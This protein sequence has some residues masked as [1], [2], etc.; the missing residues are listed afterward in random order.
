MPFPRF[1]RRTQVVPVSLGPARANQAYED[2]L[3]EEA[4]ARREAARQQNELE[5]QRLAIIQSRASQYAQTRAQAQAQAAATQAAA[6]QEAATQA[7]TAQAQA[8]TAQAATAQASETDALSFRPG[9]LIGPERNRLRREVQAQLPNTD[10]GAA[11]TAPRRIGVRN[12]VVLEHDEFGPILPTS[13]LEGQ[14]IHPGHTGNYAADYAFWDNQVDV[15]ERRI[16]ALHTTY[17]I[18]EN[19]ANVRVNNLRTRL[20]AANPPIPEEV[21]SAEVEARYN[22]IEARDELRTYRTVLARNSSSS[23]SNATQQPA[24]ARAHGQ[25]PAE[26]NRAQI[27]TAS[28][29]AVPEAGIRERRQTLYALHEKYNEV[30]RLQG[31]EEEEI[32]EELLCPLTSEF[33]V[34]PVSEAFAEHKN[35]YERSNILRAISMQ[36]QRTQPL[37]PFTRVPI[38]PCTLL[39]DKE[40]IAKM[41]KYEEKMYRYINNY[42][43]KLWV[44]GVQPQRFN[45]ASG[46]KFKKLRKLIQSVKNRKSKQRKQAKQAKQTTQANRRHAKLSKKYKKQYT[47]RYH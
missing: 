22:I 27:Q 24:P 9:A 23:T 11:P 8:A 34:D 21:I 7:A 20:E 16:A 32:P 15:E 4:I 38:Y 42:E 14:E 18:L 37:D 26:R 30:R 10:F 17:P 25:T 47:K 28:K 36:D 40:R 6:T 29:N 41:R 3:I 2:G 5:A 43:S 13:Q 1:N 35:T 44:E 19:Y 45:L 31:Q 33:M 46:K 12:V 39:P